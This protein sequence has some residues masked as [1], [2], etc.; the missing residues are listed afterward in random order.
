MSNKKTLLFLGLSALAAS[1]PV[2]AQVAPPASSSTAT[3]VYQSAFEGYRSFE[4]GDVQDWRKSNDT[5]REV[6]GWRA[7]AREMR[8]APAVPA[9]GA[10]PQGGAPQAEPKASD[11]HAGHHP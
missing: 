11:P 10:S 1:L 8:S 2:A 5:V 6:G 3:P 9:S 4:G 7:Y